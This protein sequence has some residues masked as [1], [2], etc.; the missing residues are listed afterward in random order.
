MHPD[1]KWMLPFTMVDM[2]NRVVYG[3]FGTL[4]GPSQPYFAHTIG[5]DIDTI[6]WIW[7]LSNVSTVLGSV[8]SSCTFKQYVHSSTQKMLFCIC[9]TVAMGLASLMPPY[10]KSFGGLLFA[11]SLR[12][13]LGGLLET[14]TQGLYVYTLG[15]VRSRF[16]IMCFHFTV[17]MGFWMGPLIIKPFFPV[18]NDVNDSNE[19]CISDAHNET[20]NLNQVEHSSVND[21]ILDSIKW[22]Y[23][24]VFIGHILL[25]LG[26]FLVILL[27]CKMPVYEEDETSEHQNKTSE[28]PVWRD[29]HIFAALISLYAAGCGSER[30]FQSME[31]TFSLCGPL[32]L[33]PK[34]AVF[35][36]ECYNGGFMVG[37]F[38]SIFVINV[39]PPKLMLKSSIFLCLL[40][41][42]LLSWQGD[43]SA[44]FLFAAAAFFGFAVSWQFG[45]GFS[46]TSEHMDVVGVRASIFAIGCATGSLTPIIGGY[47][48]NRVSPMALWHFNLGIVLV[49]LTSFLALH[50]MYKCRERPYGKA[51][52]Y[53]QV[54]QD[55]IPLAECDED[56]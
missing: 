29:L 56:D 21:H 41:T 54:N 1:W 24:I 11:I 18:A 26:Y 33:H 14:A 28:R 15:P 25:C 42:I 51:Y 6:N 8:L 19:V 36:D 40:S 16:L 12:N 13:F 32:K 10:M 7:P 34:Q 46:W 22:P 55:E 2:V 30:L 27:P 20:H 35:T 31:F 50:F 43:N 5:I 17:A 52:N 49:Q 53:K 44:N 37:R 3:I 47:L 38:L 45:A 23:W 39:I 48:F 4:L 9:C